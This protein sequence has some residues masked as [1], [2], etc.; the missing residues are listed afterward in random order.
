MIRRLKLAV[1]AALL[2]TAAVVPPASATPAPAP[3]AAGVP[4]SA[5]PSPIEFDAFYN[6]LSDKC[7][8]ADTNTANT[9]GGKVQ[10]WDCNW[11]FQQEW[12][13]EWD[14]ITPIKNNYPWPVKCLDADLNHIHE[15]GARVQLWDCNGSAQQAWWYNPPDFSWHNVASGKCLDADLNHIHENGAKM[16]LWDCNG[17]GQQRFLLLLYQPPTSSR[18]I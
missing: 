2:L 12:T 3:A 17:T 4:T 7:V 9:N 16:Q 18:A 8:D 1:A 11:Q 15:N 14:A 13:V 10:L 6:S 5:A